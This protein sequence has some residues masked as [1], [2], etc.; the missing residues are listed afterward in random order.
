MDFFLNPISISCRSPSRVQKRRLKRMNLE[1]IFHSETSTY[2]YL[3]WDDASSE[4]LIIDPVDEDIE[5]YLR[6]LKAKGLK[7]VCAGYAHSCRPHHRGRRSSSKNRSRS[8]GKLAGVTICGRC[9]G[10]DPSQGICGL[11][12][13]HGGLC[14]LLGGGCSRR[15]SDRRR[16][17]LMDRCA[18]VPSDAF[19]PG[20]CEGTFP[21]LNRDQKRLPSARIT[22]S[23]CSGLDSRPRERTES[24]QRILLGPCP[25]P[26]AQ[27]TR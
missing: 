15:G 1:Q 12:G 14:H 18:S 10:S 16:G 11:C 6:L 9:S 4:A 5:L 20:G 2:W 8:R 3:L 22:R 21:S 13:F 7:L 27:E 23:T 26:G 17:G 19:V 24:L 25:S